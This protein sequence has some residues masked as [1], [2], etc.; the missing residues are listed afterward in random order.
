MY[1]YTHIYIYY[2]KSRLGP[3]LSR[4]GVDVGAQ[5]EPRR[6]QN[7]T[8]TGQTTAIIFIMLVELLAEVALTVFRVRRELRVSLSSM[9]KGGF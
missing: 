8:Q 2:F 5:K 6:G 4:F 3:I 1:I 9:V 7:A